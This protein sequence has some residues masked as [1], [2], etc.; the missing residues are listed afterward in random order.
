[1]LGHSDGKGFASLLLKKL[2]FGALF[3]KMGGILLPESHNLVLNG[4]KQP[5]PFIRRF[6]NFFFIGNLIDNII[7]FHGL[8]FGKGHGSCDFRRNYR[9]DVT[10]FV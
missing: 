10:A 2:G 5:T 4:F 7:L 1:M 3:F 9:L 8:G 6:F